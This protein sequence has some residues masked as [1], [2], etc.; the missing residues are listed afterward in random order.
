MESRK[1][2]AENGKA[3]S[4]R[5]FISAIR[6]FPHLSAP[7][8]TFPRF[9]YFRPRNIPGV[10]NREMR[11]AA[12][13]HQIRNAEINRRD[14]KDAEK[15]KA[16]C[17][18]ALQSSNLLSSC[19]DFS[20]SPG[21][22]PSSGAASQEVRTAADKSDALRGSGVAAPEDGRTP[23]ACGFAALQCN[24]LT[25]SQAARILRAPPERD[26]LGSQQFPNCR[27]HSDYSGTTGPRTLLRPGT[28]ALRAVCGSA[29]LCS[30]G[31]L[32]LIIHPFDCR[33]SVERF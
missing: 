25:C 2:K 7:F 26:R 8:R 15:E 6:A 31:S 16:R 9:K 11:S 10:L 1:Q 32:W 14:A 33:L 17:P 27:P 29:A 30:L 13:P 21:V 18:S 19:E 4:V 24:R 12:E 5:A 22:R 20:D 3:E 23:A 28:V